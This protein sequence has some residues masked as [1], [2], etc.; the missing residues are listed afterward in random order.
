MGLNKMKYIKGLMIIFIFSFIGEI[1]NHLLP[2][3]LPASI[4]GMILLFIAL[5]TKCI[6]L[7][8]VEMISEFLLSVML[9]FFVPASVGIM[10]TFFDYKS[11]MLNI[12]I[13]VI[14]STIVVMI[15]TGLVA[16]TIIKLTNKKRKE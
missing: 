1:L 5:L 3:P 15:T 6:K 7:E 10:D 9:I 2:L 11:N 12:I 4:Y 14:V 8:Q 16:Q 13:T